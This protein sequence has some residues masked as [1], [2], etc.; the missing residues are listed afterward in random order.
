MAL[1]CRLSFSRC[2]AEKRS[3]QITAEESGV[4]TSAVSA[5]AAAG[6]IDTNDAVPAAIPAAISASADAAAA[7]AVLDIWK[8]SDTSFFAILAA[9]LDA[10]LVV[11]LA[12]VLQVLPKKI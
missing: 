1:F 9:V 2:S 8:N 6:G 12:A 3:A 7:A 11:V 10:V 5:A 4:A